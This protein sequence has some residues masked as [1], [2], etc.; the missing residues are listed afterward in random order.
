M[1]VVLWCLTST[2][3]SRFDLLAC[4]TFSVPMVKL[5]FALGSQ[6]DGAGADGAMPSSTPWARVVAARKSGAIM[7]EVRMLKVCIA[8]KGMVR[9]RDARECDARRIML[10]GRRETLADNGRRRDEWGGES[11]RRSKTEKQDGGWA[12]AS[13]S[14]SCNARARHSRK[15]ADLCLPIQALPCPIRKRRPAN[16]A[17]YQASPPAADGDVDIILAGTRCRT[18]IEIAI[19]AGNRDA[20][21]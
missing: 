6:P 1:G 14:C 7:V 9:P 15:D 10:S 4:W 11:Q 5:P 8:K 12:C 16:R 19:N 20:I 13:S 21:C 18:T 2:A 3:D 17:L